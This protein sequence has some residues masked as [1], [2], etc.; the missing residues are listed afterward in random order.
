MS[1]PPVLRW[2]MP[3]TCLGVTRKPIACPECGARERLYLG[4]DL[5]DDSDEPSFMSCPGGHRWLEEDMPR[6]IGAGL[7]AEV[8][9]IDPGIFARLEELQ[10]AHE[11]D[12][13]SL[14]VGNRVVTP[15]W[16]PR[17]TGQTP[18]VPL[19][20]RIDDAVRRL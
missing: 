1:T 17:A 9:D 18:S 5:D 4:M 19:S 16:G 3:G 20:N 6:R 2:P 10:R 15:R 13:Q 11:D 7:L 14:P 12:L 8:L